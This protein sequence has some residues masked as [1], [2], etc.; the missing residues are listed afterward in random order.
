MR[1]NCVT[2][3]GKYSR[4]F[5]S[6]RFALE[7]VYLGWLH[8]DRTVL[9]AVNFK[10]LIPFAGRLHVHQMHDMGQWNNTNYS[11]CQRANEKIIRIPNGREVFQHF[12]FVGFVL[13]SL[14]VFV[15]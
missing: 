14:V 8:A 6:P 15:V 10:Q 11:L 13:L 1:R 12:R 7:S 5:L 2:A 9:M 4:R 3:V